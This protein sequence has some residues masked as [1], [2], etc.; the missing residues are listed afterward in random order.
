MR[1][2]RIRP[3]LAAGI[4]LAV[5]T[6]SG[7]V[8]L[9]RA[10]PGLGVSELV[11]V[12]SVEDGDGSALEEQLRWAFEVMGD[13]RPITEADLSERFTATSAALVTAE[14]LT[15]GL[16]ILHEAHGAV[17][18]VRQI[19][20][21]PDFATGLGVGDDGVPVQ[22]SIAVSEDGA[23]AGW[24]VDEDPSPPRL[25][26]VRAALVLAAGWLFVASGVA[27]HRAGTGRQAWALVLPG[28]LTLSSILILSSSSIGYTAGRVAPTLALVLAVWL[29]TAPRPGPLRGAALGAAALAAGLAALAPLTR[30]ANL[31][32]P[33]GVLVSL[34]DS[35]TVYR[36]LL[37]SSSL[38]A[39]G[40]LTLVG[41]ATAHELRTE[42][43]WRLLPPWAALAVAV[44]WG[45][46]AF[47]S[48]LDYA[49]GD[50]S[51]AGGALSVV[52]LASLAA[53][54]VVIALGQLAA[55]WDR[56]E[57]AGLVIE[58]DS[59]GGRLQPAV[60]RALE[61]PSVQV[62]TSP[63]G[64][65]LLDEHGEARTLDDVPAGR[66]F[67]Q[68]RS[69]GRLVGG[70]IH[71]AA[72]RRQPDR[73][74]AVV[75]VAGLALEVGRLSGELAAQLQEV[76]ASRKRIIE[77][78]DGARRRIERDLHDGAQQRL[79]ALGIELQRARRLADAAGDGDLATL[80]ESA[81]GD[82][83]STIDDI[84][85]V[86]RGSHPALLVERG[87]RAA[88]DALAERSPVPVD[89]EVAAERLPGPSE[90]IAYYVVAEGL[91]NVGKHAAGA[92]RASV[93]ITRRNGARTSRSATTA[94][95]EQRSSADRGSRA[96]TI[97]WPRP[98][99][100]SPSRAAR[101]APPSRR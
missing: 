32:G 100:R 98:G 33:L 76:E 90:I 97:A 35:A 29:L 59:G 50:G 77:A 48:A 42:S 62:L 31:I 101:Q 18:F 1:Q 53:V 13:Q 19:E 95:A 20:G 7:V 57:L 84:R 9:A 65:R 38:L 74:R 68:I 86:S 71:K 12:E 10:E 61:D 43:R 11:R 70:L 37:G 26:G 21:G 58:L 99:A 46:A 72:L 79:V 15:A 34:I 63:D 40:A 60:A 28:L 52:A 27:A 2:L 56:P 44:L 5:T 94:A 14:E 69:G 4:F 41:L 91:A 49:I 51:W 8:W 39:G 81:T 96:W 75:A 73:L 55:R 25:A 36:G 47:G 83:R 22:M 78:S 66:T 64:E 82:I 3:A 85:S 30:D 16:E 17:T 93:S 89:T 88:V 23:I 80:L 87:L 54:P 67:T 6:A 24:S 45:S 92:T